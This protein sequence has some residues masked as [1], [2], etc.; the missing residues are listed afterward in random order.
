MSTNVKSIEVLA[1]EFIRESCKE[2]MKQVTEIVGSDGKVL[3]GKVGKAKDLRTIIDAVWSVI[4]DE[5][6]PPPPTPGKCTV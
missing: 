3:L 5:L 1:I 6:F 4:Q 2:W